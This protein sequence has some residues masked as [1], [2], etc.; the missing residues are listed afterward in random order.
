MRNSLQKTIKLE[1]KEKEKQCSKTQD[2][3]R[4]SDIKCKMSKDSDKAY[5]DSDKLYIYKMTEDSDKA[6]IQDSESYLQD[7]EGQWQNIYEHTAT[8]YARWW[9]NIQVR[10]VTNHTYI[11]KNS[12]KLT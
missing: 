11:R 9:Q 1:L 4:W 10:T 12:N 2:E 5:K 6:Y 8:K 3:E 7:E